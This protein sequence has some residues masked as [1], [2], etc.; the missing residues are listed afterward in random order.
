V[1]PLATAVHGPGVAGDVL[2]VVL[3]ALYW[4]PYERRARRLA[5]QGR[6]VAGWRRACYGAAIVVLI[7]ALSSPLGDLSE[8]LL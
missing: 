1:G 4:V 8:K 2:V 3:A 6:P 7:I 5:R